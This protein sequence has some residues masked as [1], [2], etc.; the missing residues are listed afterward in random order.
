MHPLYGE[1]QKCFEYDGYSTRAMNSVMDSNIDILYSCFSQQTDHC[2]NPVIRQS[3]YSPPLPPHFSA[4]DMVKP[5]YSYIAL[6]TMAIH[7]SPEKKTTLNGIYQ[8]IMERFPFYRENKQGWQNSIRHNLSLNECFLKVPRDNKKP[9]KGSYWTLDPDSVDMF[10]NG[11]YL[12]RR[13]RFK[14]KNVSLEKEYTEGPM[15]E[16]EGRKED[17]Q[18]HETNI[19][20]RIKETVNFSNKNYGGEEVVMFKTSKT[21]D[22]LTSP[23]LSAQDNEKIFKKFPKYETLEE[24]GISSCMQ[25]ILRNCK[26][27]TKHSSSSHN[28]V[29]FSNTISEEFL[30]SSCVGNVS[31]STLMSP[32]E[33]VNYFPWVMSSAVHDESVVP[34]YCRKAIYSCDE[35]DGYPVYSDSPMVMNHSRAAARGVYHT[36]NASQ[37]PIFKKSASK[38]ELCNQTVSRC[39]GD[40]NGLLTEMPTQESFGSSKR[41]SSTSS[42][43]YTFS[44]IPEPNVSASQPF[45]TEAF[46]TVNG[47]FCV[48]DMFESQQLPA[49][50]ASVNPN[51]QMVFTNSTEAYP[52]R[53][54]TST[55]YECSMV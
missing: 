8:F 47:N 32:R 28:S 6:I 41:Q 9:G 7:N 4:K 39:F 13:R 15:K 54:E 42:P 51:C 16:S 27:G 48:R 26:F 34:P 46:S 11:S 44:P 49:T 2:S 36:E 10:D 52:V 43:Y 33:S 18:S 29:L 1:K 30:D 53:S 19:P 23:S 21:R 20:S 35:L 25:Q 31:G 14:K 50:T 22:L 12:R 24:C 17:D 3:T 55:R 37:L 38:S 5:P 45:L 40:S